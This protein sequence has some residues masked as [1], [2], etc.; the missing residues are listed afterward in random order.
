ML[1]ASPR[2]A[3]DPADLAG[4]RLTDVF[5]ERYRNALARTIADWDATYRRYGYVVPDNG[6]RRKWPDAAVL[7][8]ID[9]FEDLLNR[10]RCV[11]LSPAVDR[12]LHPDDARRPLSVHFDGAR[13][14]DLVRFRRS[15]RSLTARFL[16]FLPERLMVG[17]A[18][19]VIALMRV[20]AIALDGIRESAHAH[21]F[22]SL[23]IPIE[24]L[25]LNLWRLYFASGALP[26]RFELLDYDGAET[27][28]SYLA[29]GFVATMSAPP[30]GDSRGIVGPAA[31]SHGG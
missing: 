10:R 5:E 30:D 7:P 22:Q 6:E 11:W 1:S 23:P 14:G 28:L 17:A 29:P 15:V 21:D 8:P 31:P 4:R 19:P 20:G 16:D 9:Q 24:P 27:G 12:T 3:I 26:A 2:S 18:L 13:S 25:R